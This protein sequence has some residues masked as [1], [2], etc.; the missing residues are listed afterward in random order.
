MEGAAYGCCLHGVVA[1]LNRRSAGSSGRALTGGR[2]GGR[3]MGPMAA[4]S[5][6]DTILG[7]GDVKYHLVDPARAHPQAPAPA[8][9]PTPAGDALPRRLA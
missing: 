5:K 3:Q 9:A 8:P 1:A 6:K 7:S 2:G 4:D